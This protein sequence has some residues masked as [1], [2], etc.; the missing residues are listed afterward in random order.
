MLR[1]ERDVGTWSCSSLVSAQS[2]ADSKRRSNWS[3]RRYDL[4]LP[5]ALWVHMFCG[6]CI[7][8]LPKALF[9]ADC[10]YGN[11]ITTLEKSC[12]PNTFQVRAKITREQNSSN[13]HLPEFLYRQGMYFFPAIGL[14]KSSVHH[15]FF[16]L[17]SFGQM[18]GGMWGQ[19]VSCEVYGSKLFIMRSFSSR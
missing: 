17:L 19:A 3:F 6:S 4:K 16:F 8:S 18:I 15:L 11:E 12:V 5:V 2:R 10:L 13:K 1:L 14:G 9:W 7:C